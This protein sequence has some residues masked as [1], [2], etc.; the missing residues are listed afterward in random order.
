MTPDG[1]TFSPL[2]LMDS[3][4]WKTHMERTVMCH[5]TELLFTSDAHRSLPTSDAHLER[6][7]DL[8][9]LPRVKSVCKSLMQNS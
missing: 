1:E 8:L 5:D 4:N 7:W 6:L 9:F 3:E 2:L